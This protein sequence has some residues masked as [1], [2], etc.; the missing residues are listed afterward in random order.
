MKLTYRHNLLSII[1]IILVFPSC[2]PPSEGDMNTT[3]NTKIKEQRTIEK[4]SSKTLE[5]P[6]TISFFNPKSLPVFLERLDTLYSAIYAKEMETDFVQDTL[7]EGE[8]PRP[9]L[10]NTEAEQLFNESVELIKYKFFPREGEDLIFEFIDM[11]FE[12]IGQAQNAF[13]VI[14]KIAL[15][16]SGTPGLTYTNDWLIQEDRHLYWLNTGCRYAYFNHQK[17][18]SFLKD[19]SNEITSTEIY[20]KCGMLTCQQGRSEN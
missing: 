20:C 13:R 4:E 10:R 19:L 7:Q 5:T 2:Q 16:V 1:S 18:I 8:I 3:A 14:G 6:P 12:T 9:E 17:I 11:E 15:E